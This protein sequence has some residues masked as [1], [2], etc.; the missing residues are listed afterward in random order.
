MERHVARRQGCVGAAPYPSA[1]AARP[2]AGSEEKE[3]EAHWTI[4]ERSCRPA[5]APAEAHFARPHGV[6]PCREMIALLPRCR[7]AG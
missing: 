3:L 7:A 5:E 6:R 4:M 1:H 2:K